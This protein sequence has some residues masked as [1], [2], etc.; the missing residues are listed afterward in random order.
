MRKLILISLFVL[1]SVLITACG[2][3]TTAAPS[4][5]SKP[6]N[7]EFNTNP[8]PA[9][10]GDVELVFTV[11]DVEGN[12]LEGATVDV[13]ADHTD[14]TDM[15]MGGPATDQGNGRYAI[16]ANFSMSGNWKLTVYIRKDGLDYKEDID[17][18]IQ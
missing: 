9:A 4:A 7:L 5:A 6:V 18:K 11:T 17:F 2:G 8:N 10:T 16:N 1:L 3:T 13:S 14:M 12:P 15:T